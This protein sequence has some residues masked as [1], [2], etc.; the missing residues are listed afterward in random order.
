MR[1]ILF[2]TC[3]I[4]AHQSSA[5]VYK[6]YSDDGV[7]VWVIEP[8]TSNTTLDQI[9]SRITTGDCWSTSEPSKVHCNS[10]TESNGEYGL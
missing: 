5:E 3:L 8:G 10:D 2:I 1:Q 6:E 9:R 7:D 4:F